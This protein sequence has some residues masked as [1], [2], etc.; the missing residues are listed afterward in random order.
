MIWEPAQDLFA[1]AQTS[2]NDDE[3]S[4]YFIFKWKDALVNITVD[5]FFLEIWNS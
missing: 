3:I 2:N 1:L 5:V 4:F